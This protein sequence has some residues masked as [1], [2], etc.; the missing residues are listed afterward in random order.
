MAKITV[1][2]AGSWGTA[3]ADLA[4]RRG[5]DVTLWCRSDDQARAINLTG[6]N[7]RYLTEAA[8]APAIVATSSMEEAA[9]HSGRWLLAIPTQALRE[10]LAGLAPFSPTTVS[11]CNV[12]KGIEIS[13]RKLIHEIV[14]ELLPHA[15]YSILSGP[16]H[17]EDVV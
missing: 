14:E 3:L 12:A 4:A 15:R 11:A 6:H 7:P 16:S 1:F 2:G 13:S 9:G 10:V 8:L 5:H 17:A